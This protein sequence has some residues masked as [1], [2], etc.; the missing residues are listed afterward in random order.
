MCSVLNC[1]E[2]RIRQR[3]FIPDKKET[4]TVAFSNFLENHNKFIY[5]IILIFKMFNQAVYTMNFTRVD[6]IHCL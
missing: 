6:S 5:S 1:F 2:T 3:I 4:H